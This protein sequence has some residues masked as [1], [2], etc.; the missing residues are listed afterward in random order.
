MVKEQARHR[1]LERLLSEGQSLPEGSAQA[2]SSTA[3]GCLGPRQSQS[4]QVSVHAHDEGFRSLLLGEQG[5]SGCSTAYV[6][7]AVARPDRRLMNEPFLER[8]LLEKQPDD[9]I[10]EAGQ[11]TEPQSWDVRPSIS[12]FAFPEHSYLPT[13]RGSQRGSPR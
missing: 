8:L 1:A 11:K 12:H 2:K 5:Q 9:T 3:S 10:V 7:N 13:A 6:Q 4:L